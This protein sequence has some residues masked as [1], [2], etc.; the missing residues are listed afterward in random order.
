M[1]NFRKQHPDLFIL[2]CI[3]GS[4]ALLM[5]FSFVCMLYD[6]GT[7]AKAVWSAVG[8]GLYYLPSLQWICWFCESVHVFRKG[9]PV[10][11]VCI[12]NY[13][14][15]RREHYLVTWEDEN[16]SHT[17]D[18]GYAT[19]RVRRLPYPVKLYCYA[20]KYCLGMESVISSGISALLLLL[21]Q[22]AIWIPIIAA[23]RN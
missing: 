13:T 4:F 6:W 23:L 16:G 22:S 2:L 10:D 20:G 11:A 12:G 19:L 18:L 5:G 14:S 17:E 8:L 9:T 1:M 15:S 7:P 3:F 21:V